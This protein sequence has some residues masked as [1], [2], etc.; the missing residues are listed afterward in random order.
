MIA[1]DLYVGEN[2]LPNQLSSIDPDLE[3]KRLARCQIVVPV[4]HRLGRIG[5]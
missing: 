1:L 4:R 3:L 5:S 2:A